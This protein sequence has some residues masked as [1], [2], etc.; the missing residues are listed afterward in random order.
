MSFTIYSKQGCPFCEK[1]IA[2]MEHEE[3]TYVVYE[4]DKD[5]TIDEFYAE[6]GEG[7]T[8]PQITLDGIQLGGCQETVKYLQ[9]NNVCCNV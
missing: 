4:L 7:S 9:K 3:F 1:C 2:V 5:F 8:F 6:F